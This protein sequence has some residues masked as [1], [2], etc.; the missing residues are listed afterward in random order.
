MPL[1]CLCWLFFILLVPT[2]AATSNKTDGKY[3]IRENITLLEKTLGNSPNHSQDQ[4]QDDITV[5]HASSGE[6]D[7]ENGKSGH[8]ARNKGQMSGEDKGDPENRRKTGQLVS[9]TKNAGKEVVQEGQRPGMLDTKD[10]KRDLEQKMSD[11][12]KDTETVGKTTRPSDEIANYKN[13]Q[14]NMSLTSSSDQTED[15]SLNT[16][17]SS[18]QRENRNAQNGNF[19]KRVSSDQ[20]G[21]LTEIGDEIKR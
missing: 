20:K 9:D 18:D 6:K 1:S 16:N 15:G 7:E 8:S 11:R 17:I 4:I 10:G 13:P 19:A 5:Q 2:I 12:L 21:K 14:N 3:G